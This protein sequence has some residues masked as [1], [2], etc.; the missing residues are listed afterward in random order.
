[1]S[2]SGL[3]A[4]LLALLVPPVCAL[5]GAT[6]RPAGEVMCAGCRST[7]PWLARARCRRCGLPSPCR[8]CPARGAAFDTAWAPLAYDGG[9]RRAITALKFAG[10]LA[11][12]DAMAAQMASGAPTA[13]V[14]DATLVPVPL[15]PARRRRRG[16][17]QAELLARSLSRR[18]RLP[19]SRCLMRRG[20]PNR[21]LGAGRAVRLAPARLEF[22]VGSPAPTRALLVDDVHTTGATLDACARALRAGGARQVGCL[23]YARTLPG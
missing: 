16:F 10:A 12:A 23:T 7:L 20:N 1:V 9:A 6:M 11:L 14:A 21:Q 3:A 18:L 22:T 8:D 5:C 15:H 4:Q 19:L 17:N 13:L 2:A